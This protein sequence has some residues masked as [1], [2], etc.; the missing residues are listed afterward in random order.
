MLAVRGSV[1][2][3]LLYLLAALPFGAAAV[4]RTDTLCFCSAV[5]EGTVG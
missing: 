1:C 4:P 3:S 2:A 5:D